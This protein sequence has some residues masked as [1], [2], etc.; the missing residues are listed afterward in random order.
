MT[1]EQ[2]QKFAVAMAGVKQSQL[3]A[4]MYAARIN[5]GIYKTRIVKHGSLDGPLYSEQELLQD[6]L[7]TM[8]RHIQLAEERLEYAQ[9]IMKGIRS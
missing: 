7:A 2:Q 9:E 8:N 4:E 3:R 6:E 5:T 1:T